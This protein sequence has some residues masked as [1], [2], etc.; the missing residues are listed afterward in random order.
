MKPGDTSGQ[1]P[2]GVGL[3][4]MDE[5]CTAR[6]TTIFKMVFKGRC[7]HVPAEEAKLGIVDLDTEENAWDSFR[8]E[9]PD[10]PAIVMSEKPSEIKGTVYVSKPA[11]LDV[12]WDS[13]FNIVT[14]LPRASDLN[15]GEE[16]SNVVSL[17]DNQAAATNTVVKKAGVSSAAG[18][19]ETRA[20]TVN[21]VRKTVQKPGPRDVAD[22]YFNPDD[23]LLGRMAAS[24]KENADNDCVIDVKCW[25]DRKLL[26]VPK[27]N[28]AYTDLKDNQLKNLGVATF[29][30]EFSV[31]INTEQRSLT[32]DEV[33][34]LRS[35]PL[36][37]LLWDLALRT[38]RG[39][40]PEGTQASSVHYLKCWPNFTRLPNTPNGMRIAALWAGKPRTFD[41]IAANLDIS[42]ED[43]YSF[44]SAA[45]M[46]C[47]AGNAERKVDN[48]VAPD[49]V[50]KKEIT[51][52]GLLSSI[53]RQ[54]S[55][56]N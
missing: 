19:M 47:Q 4:G 50:Q 28:K 5:R 29:S 15:K 42:Q 10:L 35:I 38:A 41:D 51:R 55:K 23:Y 25:R 56:K 2:I 31:E 11:K 40:L 20:D 16:S 17:A 14:G 27:Q 32:E 7:E 49:A 34:G 53:L 18:L 22:I 26:L 43:V 8:K 44:Y 33:Q 6:M 36:E 39:R 13:I 52:R 1:A 45:A 54:I 24:I 9:Y 12:L 30:D 48:L 3:F 21:T 46:T 37:Y